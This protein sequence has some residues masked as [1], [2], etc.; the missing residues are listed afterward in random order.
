M[1]NIDFK[2]RISYASRYYGLFGSV[3]FES[4][5]E[6]IDTL[7]RLNSDE[8]SGLPEMLVLIHPKWYEQE[9]IKIADPRGNRS[10]PSAKTG[11]LCRSQ[12]IYGYECNFK[13]QPIHIDHQFPYSKGGITNYENAMYLCAEHNLS[14][15]TDIHLIDWRSISTEWVSGILD[16]FVH[17]IKRESGASILKYSKVLNRPW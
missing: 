10:F 16:K 11:V 8:S 15:S 17:E 12:E 14:K 13:D 1:L 7:Q 9:I 6:W 3:N 2:E 4:S 5:H